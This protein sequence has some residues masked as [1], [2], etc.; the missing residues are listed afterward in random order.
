M[1]PARTLDVSD[2]PPYHISNRSPLFWGQ[3]LL[4]AIE[5]TMFCILIA[6]YFYIRMSVD[7]W[8]PP[9]VPAPRPIFATL[10][11]R[12]RRWLRTG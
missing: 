9:G 4:C 6:T 1:S 12:L 10:A 5:G 7:V 8:P 2:L 11:L 3:V